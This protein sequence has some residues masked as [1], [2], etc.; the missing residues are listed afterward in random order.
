MKH[1]LKILSIVG[2]VV[3]LSGCAYPALFICDNNSCQEPSNEIKASIQ[4]NW[5][6]QKTKTEVQNK[7]WR[8]TESLF[9]ERPPRCGSDGESKFETFRIEDPKHINSRVL[10]CSSEKKYWVDEYGI[11]Y[12]VMQHRLQGPFNLDDKK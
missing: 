2:C 8:N 3:Y 6:I 10:Y 11:S 5:K 1:Y 12:E 9:P 7:K 4:G